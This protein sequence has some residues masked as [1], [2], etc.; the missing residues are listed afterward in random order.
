MFDMM[1]NP[2]TR[3]NSR[4]GSALAP[5]R[6]LVHLILPF[7]MVAPVAAAVPPDRTKPAPCTVPPGIVDTRPNPKGVPTRVSFTLYVIDIGAIND[8]EQSFTAD[9]ILGLRWKDPRLVPLAHCK[10]RLAGVWNP[11][12]VFLNLTDMA[13]QYKDI[14]VIG[15][16][17]T[18]DYVQ[19]FVGDVSSPVDLRDF[20]F[21]RRAC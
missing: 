17:G 15:S 2:G 3:R 4:A 13:K 21:D 12:L 1:Q 14:V 20:P 19:R 5:V 18:V 7:L 6:W 10:F 11:P 9:I 16:D 8:V